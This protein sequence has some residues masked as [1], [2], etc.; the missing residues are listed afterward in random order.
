MPITLS[1]TSGAGS[2]TLVNNA[3]AGS[4]SFDLS[5]SVGPNPSVTPSV[6]L[7]PSVSVTPSISVTP[8]VTPSISITPSTT[9]SSVGD[10]I[11]AALSTS[12]ASYDAAIVGDWVKV[13]SAEYAN[14]KATVSGATTRGMTDAQANEA[15]SA[16]TGICA[17]VLTQALVTSPS[18]EYLIAF[19]ARLFNT[20]GTFTVL[21]STAY[22]GT[23]TSL[24]N[25][26]S[27]NS[28]NG[29]EYWVRKAP[30]TAN[31]S[32]TY[33][34]SVAS[35]NRYLSTTT[36]ANTFYDCSSPYSTWTSWN[37]LTCPVFQ[38]VGTSTKSW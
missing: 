21:T 24:G 10:S 12:V 33:V 34:G 13:T 28:A 9:P 19:S 14:V 11:R 3:N 16:W 27:A 36:F 32:T 29:R 30:T 5:G 38:F 8:S 22:G 35:A 20:T 4:I 7:T 2:F 26:P 1:N 6:S 23:Y 25:S 17:H 37:N 18:G 15:G 31:A